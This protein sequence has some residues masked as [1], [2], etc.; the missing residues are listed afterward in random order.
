MLEQEFSP[1]GGSARAARKFALDASALTGES[2]ERFEIVVSEVV[3]NAILHARTRFV[4][5]VT[6]HPTVRVEVFD[7]RAA[8]PVRKDYGPR[9]TTGRG[10][11]LV[12]ELADRWGSEPTDDGKVVWFEFD[13]EPGA[14]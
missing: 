6:S 8:P 4:V 3:T 7:G 9:A 5:R 2:A 1:D 12:D 13:R 11:M 14:A 10:V